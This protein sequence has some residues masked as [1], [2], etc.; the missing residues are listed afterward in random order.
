MKRPTS[1][2][3]ENKYEAKRDVWMERRG[4]KWDRAAFD[5]YKL[6]GWRKGSWCAKKGLL[7]LT[8]Q[9]SFDFF[10]CFSLPNPY[11]QHTQLVTTD[12]SVQRQQATLDG[13]A[14]WTSMGEPDSLV[15]GSRGMQ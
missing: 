14:G 12:Y 9:S 15:A 10:P 3:G 4:R 2:W 1:S 8:S 7:L 13:L 5:D 11:E 6:V